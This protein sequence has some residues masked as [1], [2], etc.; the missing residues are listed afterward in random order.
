MKGNGHKDKPEHWAILVVPRLRIQ[1]VN[2]ISSPMTWGFPSITAF[3]GLMTSLE[4]RLGVQAGISFRAIGVVCHN[5]EAQITTKGFTRAFHLTRN[6]LN[7]D[8]STAG[9]AEEGRAHLDLSLVFSV[10]ISESHLGEEE[11]QSMANQITH[12]LG[13]MRLA[14]GSIMPSRASAG[15]RRAKASLALE[16]QG[17]EAERQQMRELARSCL[18]GFALVSR[19]DLLAG[20]LA[21]LRELDP[22]MTVLDA[23]LDLSCLTYRATQADQGEVVW[24][25]DARNGWIVPIPVGYT[26]ISQLYPPGVVQAAR[27]NV[28]PFRFVETIWSIGEWISPHRLKNLDDLF[29]YARTENEVHQTYRCLND[30]T[31]EVAD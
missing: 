22:Q 4:R 3:L 14:G 23:W 6:P 18:P 19:S 29:W 7:K 15:Y 31:P 24:Q 12:E 26:S 2:A 10:Q 8:G 5:F 25:T 17:E 28:T 30:Y 1:N 9:I 16:A 11:R 20:R 21:E 13:G 27:D